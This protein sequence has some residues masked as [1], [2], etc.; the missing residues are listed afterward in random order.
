MCPFCLFS[1]WRWIK[2]SCACAYNNKL[3]RQR[4]TQFQANYTTRRTMYFLP[5]CERAEH[6]DGTYRHNAKLTMN[7]WNKWITIWSSNL[8]CKRGDTQWQPST[9]HEAPKP[10]RMNSVCC[11]HLFAAEKQHRQITDFV[12]IDLFQWLQSDA[13][14][15]TYHVTFHFGIWTEC[16]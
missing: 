4:Q 14:F 16:A 7:S 3:S 8:S 10:H 11:K 13:L 12:L 2:S 1:I 6:R 15:C 5:G 9:K